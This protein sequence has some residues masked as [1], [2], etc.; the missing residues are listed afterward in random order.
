MAHC[1][2]A[3][4]LS[5]QWVFIYNTLAKYISWTKYCQSS[6]IKKSCVH[7]ST[8]KKKK[9]HGIV[10]KISNKFTAGQK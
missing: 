5:E 1:A 2:C 3:T 4:Y 9:I 10:G 7:S 6:V 8:Y